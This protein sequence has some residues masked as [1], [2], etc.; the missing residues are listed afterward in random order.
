MDREEVLVLLVDRSLAICSRCAQEI[1]ALWIHSRTGH[2][3]T[4]DG[5]GRI[6]VWL[7]SDAQ[8]RGHMQQEAGPQTHNPSDS[9][10]ENQYAQPDDENRVVDRLLLSGHTRPELERVGAHS[11]QLSTAHT[12]SGFSK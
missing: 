7:Y 1:D 6:A 9:S 8:T 12:V 4:G 11:Q 10:P 5:S 2:L 3:V